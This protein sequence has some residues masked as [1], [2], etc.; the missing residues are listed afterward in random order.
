LATVGR[1]PWRKVPLYM[2]A[3]YVG[4]FI[5]SV[6][7][8]FVYQNALDD[9]S[10]GNYTITTAGIWATYPQ[11]FLSI[12]NGLGDQVMGTALLAACLLAITDNKNMNTPKGVIPLMVGMVVAVIG[13]SYGYNCG[14]AINPAR[15]LAPR[16][17]TSIAGWGMDVFSYND[18]NWWWIPVVGPHI[19][20][21][22]GAVVYKLMVE[23]HWP[24]DDEDI[25]GP[26]EM[27][28][29]VRSLR[30]KSELAAV[31]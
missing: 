15:D 21:V 4:A 29:S 12:G 18:Y 20:A 5:A 13:M 23:L 17:F 26:V 27:S 10:G 1:F 11:D 6:F 28:S 22:L 8:Y 30:I 2:I 24:D 19:G 16:V 14:Y 3:Q 9:F 31:S 25:N 7:I